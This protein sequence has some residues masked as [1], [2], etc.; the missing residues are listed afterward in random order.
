MNIIIKDLH[1]RFGDNQVLKGL[2][3]SIEKGKIT[4]IVGGSGV[5]KSVLLKLIMGLIRPDNGEI[6]LDGRDITK[7]PER[8]LLPLRQKIGLVFQSGGLL[9]SLNVEENIALPLK[10]HR[11][12]EPDKIASIVSE[13][14]ELMDLEG[15]EQEMPSSLSGGMRKRVS[16]ARALA[17]NP[18]SMLY[19]EPTSALDP[20]MAETIDNLIL[21]LNKEMGMTTVVV[22]HDLHSIFKIA[23]TISMLHD[24]VIIESGTPDEFKGS[25]NEYVKDFLHRMN[26]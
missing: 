8:E 24:G 18:D 5:G 11:L 23:D 22:T 2:N 19:D 4:V 14:L 7:L 15:K 21:R 26:E 17:L 16:I 12:A 3:L 1:K 13:K 9:N 25:S 10:E 6:H 20:P